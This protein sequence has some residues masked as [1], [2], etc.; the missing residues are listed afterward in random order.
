VEFYNYIE[1]KRIA[2]NLAAA[3]FAPASKAS[4]LLQQDLPEE[5]TGAAP[6][7]AAQSQSKKPMD[8]KLPEKRVVSERGEEPPCPVCKSKH[9]LWQCDEFK[10]LSTNKK[11]YATRDAGFCYHCLGHSHSAKDCTW[12]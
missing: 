12:H 2:L 10:A 5:D 3:H 9:K 11:Y 6:V 1:Q 7:F 8:Q 4:T